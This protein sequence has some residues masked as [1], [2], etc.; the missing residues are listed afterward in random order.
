MNNANNNNSLNTYK[1]M[2]LHFQSF[3]TKKANP[4]DNSESKFPQSEAGV[5]L[6]TNP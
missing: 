2:P 4:Q 5:N 6:L 3:Y 1:S